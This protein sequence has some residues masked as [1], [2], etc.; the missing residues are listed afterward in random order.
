MRGLIGRKVGMT[1]VFDANGNRVPVT[2]VDVKGNVVVQKKVAQSRDGYTAVKLGFEECAR[3]EKSGLVRFRG[4]N[5]PEAG[6]FAKLGIEVPRRHL[7]E[8]RINAEDLDAYEVGKEVLLDEEFSAGDIVDVTGISKGHG[9]TGV[10]RRHRFH[11]P[12]QTHG[13]HEYKR[14][15]G[16]I[17]ASADPSRVIKGK[18]MPGQHG[19]T[20]TT[21]QNLAVVDV[22]PED[23]VILI[24]G[25]VPGPDGGI[26]LVKR[27]VKRSRSYLA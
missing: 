4:A 11:R 17:G 21:V 20:R 26:V 5:K 22:L 24:R 25:G 7:R 8:F 27:A 14:H 2:V 16:A 18:R 23:G 12:K 15:P 6:V 3:Q 19:N 13:T 10:I 9:F 1:Q